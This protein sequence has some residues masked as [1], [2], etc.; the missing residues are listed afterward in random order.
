MAVLEGEPVDWKTLDVSKISD[1]T[2][3]L[4]LVEQ[5]QAALKDVIK[6]RGVPE[7]ISFGSNKDE[8]KTADQPVA[9][10]FTEEQFADL[11]RKEHELRTSSATQQAYTEA[12]RSV[13][14]DWMEV[15]DGLQRRVLRDAGVHEQQLEEALSDFRAAPYHY[16]NLKQIPIYHKFQRSRQGPLNEGDPVPENLNLVDLSSGGIANFTALA[17][18]PRPIVIL[19]G[20]WT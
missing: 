17:S 19:A 3:L 4:T 14:T 7:Q 10:M 12:E 9:L 2:L 20:S 11:L 13:D 16:P 8:P 15:T 6:L 18:G 1:P 5:A